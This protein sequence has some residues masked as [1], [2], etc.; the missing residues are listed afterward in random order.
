G[1]TAGTLY[2]VATPIGNLEDITLRAI[3]ILKEVDFIA[4][5]D[6]R[7]TRKLLA[8]LQIST[9]LIA[10]YREQERNRSEKLLDLLKEGKNIALVSDAGT[11]CISDPGAL[12]VSLA[13][14]EG[15]CVSP[16]PGPSALTTALS[17]AGLTGEQPILFCGFPPGKKKARQS[18]PQEEMDMD[19]LIC[20]YRDHS[21]L[22]LKDC[23]HK[24]S[25]DLGLSRAQ[26]YKRALELWSD[27]NE[28][29]LL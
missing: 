21:T 17:C 16:I 23:S 25:Q 18:A 22:S 5:E 14:E 12:V 24:L 10:Y 4:A 15:I 2:I 11:P 13:H 9:K 29:A 27:D 3:R 6:T 26:V 8:H 19:S 28:K 20:W 1:K 7:H